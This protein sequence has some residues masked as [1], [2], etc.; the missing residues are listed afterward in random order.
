[1]FE[2]VI[3]SECGDLSED[4]FYGSADANKRI[5]FQA[6]LDWM[7]KVNAGGN[8]KFLKCITGKFD[9]VAV[10]SIVDIKFSDSIVHKLAPGKLG[11]KIAFKEGAAV[12][13]AM[14]LSEATRLFKAIA[15]E[16]D[17]NGIDKNEVD[18][19]CEN[20]KGK[21]TQFSFYYDSD[22]DT[23]VIAKNIS[24]K[25]AGRFI[26]DASSYVARAARTPTTPK[27]LVDKLSDVEEQIKALEVK[28][29]SIYADM[30]TAAAD[31]IA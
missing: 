1:M 14:P 5:R 4:E 28:R 29:A 18:V 25:T 27:T 7:D 6:M 20:E 2:E 8:S 31:K 13:A 12:D 30:D 11:V 19:F 22:T 17:K 21:L 15:A 10:N 26:K 3:L 24:A 23:A 16:C 9:G